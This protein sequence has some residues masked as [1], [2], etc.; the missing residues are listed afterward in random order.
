MKNLLLAFAGGGLWY[1]AGVLTNTHHFW[2]VAPVLS[3]FG[4][5]VLAILA[6][7]ANR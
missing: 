1:L 2:T 7:R 5:L 6:S 3:A 4:G